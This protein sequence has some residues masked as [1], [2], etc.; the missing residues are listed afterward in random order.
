MKKNLKTLLCSVM[1]LSIFTLPLMGCRT[2]TTTDGNKGT[3]NGTTTDGNKA[4]TDGN[5]TTTNGTTTNGTK[6]TTD[7][8]NTTTDGT[9][10]TKRAQ[11]ISTKVRAI[12]G[13]SRDA[14]VVN[15]NTA[16]VGVTL[17]N[18]DMKL[19]DNMRKSIETAVKEVDPKITSVKITNDTTLFGRIETMGKDVMNGKTMTDI[20]TN[21][22][23]L[24]NDIR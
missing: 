6:T 16:I 24:V 7:G 1:V 17:E 12:K 22:N 20:R 2:T 21:F 18:T 23:T 8:T 4:T 19:D 3:T 14:V 11:D 13:V 10:D 5:K 9:M 15:D